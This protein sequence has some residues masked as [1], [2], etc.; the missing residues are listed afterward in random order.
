[1]DQCADTLLLLV[2]AL[3]SRGRGDP[4]QRARPPAMSLTVLENPAPPPRNRPLRLSA[5]PSDQ[6]ADAFS[7]NVVD[8]SPYR[9]KRVGATGLDP[10]SQASSFGNG[11]PH[12][13]RRRPTA[14][15]RLDP[16]SLRLRQGLECDVAQTGCVTRDRSCQGRDGEYPKRTVD[17]AR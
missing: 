5:C 4:A 1:M 12:W 2:A 7:P 16:Q 17:F 13:P 9:A 3:R 8:V 14:D 15:V 10:S 11:W 6:S